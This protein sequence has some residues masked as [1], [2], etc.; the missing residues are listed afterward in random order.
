MAKK[1]VTA[2]A[3]E[4][5]K[6][7]RVT[8]KEKAMKHIERCKKRGMVPMSFEAVLTAYAAIGILKYDDV[9]EMSEQYADTFIT[10]NG[11][12]A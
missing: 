4:E 5:A 12:E 6:V 2:T 9:M 11:K 1:E 3:T 7:K 8:N 10:D